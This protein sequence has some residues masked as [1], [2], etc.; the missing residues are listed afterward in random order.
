MDQRDWSYLK[1]NIIPRGNVGQYHQNLT[2]LGRSPVSAS[3]HEITRGWV[4]AASSDL[5]H[6]VVG[7]I[8]RICRP[9]RLRC[10]SPQPLDV[11]LHRPRLARCR[12]SIM[13]FDCKATER[14]QGGTE[15]GADGWKRGSR[16]DGQV[17]DAKRWVG[18][19][20]VT[21]PPSCRC[22]RHRGPACWLRGDEKLGV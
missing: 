6:H 8:K 3:A 2:L 21:P 18:Q 17:H 10:P 5:R 12:Y 4:S 13:L 7:Q 1:G 15:R 11:F 16:M 9:G 14:R 22:D 20:K 19:L